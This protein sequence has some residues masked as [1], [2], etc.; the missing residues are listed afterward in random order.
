MFDDAISKECFI[1]L[2]H[3]QTKCSAMNIVCNS[4]GKYHTRQSQDNH[5]RGFTF[6]SLDK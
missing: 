5:N 3:R 6:T 2:I 4:E 1:D